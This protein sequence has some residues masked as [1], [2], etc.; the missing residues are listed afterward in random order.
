ALE[1]R[2][3]TGDATLRALRPRQGDADLRWRNRPRGTGSS[4]RGLRVGWTR[5]EDHDAVSSERNRQANRSLEETRAGESST[6]MRV[7]GAIDIGGT[8]TKLGLVTEHG[9]I[10]ARDRIATSVEGAPEP[11]VEAIATAFTAMMRSH[12]A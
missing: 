6:L 8:S 1:L 4:L 9:T 5:S 3:P 7:A 12:E 10:I 2:I 11:L